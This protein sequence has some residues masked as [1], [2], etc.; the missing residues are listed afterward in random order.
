MADLP[1][2][3]LADY[4]SLLSSYPQAQSNIQTQQAQQ[5][6][7]RAQIPL[8]GAQTSLMGAQAQR[9]QAQLGFLEQAQQT[10]AAANAPNLN[11]SSAEYLGAP[12][13]RSDRPQS[14]PG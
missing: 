11:D 10:M 1:V 13:P 14:Q 12:N 2:T 7:T 9:M 8:V 5:A 6:L 3:P 4:G